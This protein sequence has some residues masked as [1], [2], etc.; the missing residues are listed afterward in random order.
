MKKLLMN[1]SENVLSRR[2]MKTVKG[3]YGAA[4]CR[5]DCSPVGVPD[6]TCKGKNCSTYS[7]ANGGGCESETEKTPCLVA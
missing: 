7:D 5:K 2:Q 6:V 4:E 1:F 3:G